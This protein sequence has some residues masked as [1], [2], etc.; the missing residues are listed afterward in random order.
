MDP[1]MKT[2]AKPGTPRIAPVPQEDWT[3]EQRT[4]IEKSR[5]NGRDLNIITTLGHHVELLE[6][7]RVFSRYILRDNTLS[8]YD[9]EVLIVRVGWV[10]QAEYEFAHHVR[11]ALLCGVTEEEIEQIKL[12]PS[13]PGLSRNNRLLIEAVDQLLEQCCVDNAL[14]EE[15]KSVYDT[16]QLM[17]IVYT[18]GQYNL[19]SMAVNSFGVQLDPDMGLVPLD[20]PQDTDR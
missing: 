2:G 13:A 17:D 18:V 20:P 6:N 19:V 4:A 15:L 14:W 3:P 5:V 16:K 1:K 8:A 10:L 9:R 12:G 11:L 7:W